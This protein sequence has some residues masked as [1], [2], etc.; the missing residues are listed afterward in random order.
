MST[1]P[2]CRHL[3]I[4]SDITDALGYIHGKELLHNDIKPHNI[5]LGGVNRGAV[6]CDF[7][8]A[9]YPSY[10]GPNNGG[11]P[12]YIAPE[13]LMGWNKRS[14][15]SDIFAFGVTM[16][17]VTGQIPLPQGTW[18]ITD[19]TE[20]TEARQDFMSWLQFLRTAIRGVPERWR[21]MKEMLRYNAEERIKI[22]AL[23]EQVRI[24]ATKRPGGY[25]QQGQLLLPA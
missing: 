21:L 8:I 24:L 3:N 6:L 17:F 19:V 9:T 12:N 7:G 1:V 2:G 15:H 20:K 22:E 10:P 4:F 14:F 13:C 11:T 25:S 5:I 23:S 16:L 18:A